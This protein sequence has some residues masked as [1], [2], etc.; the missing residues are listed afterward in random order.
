MSKDNKLAIYLVILLTCC[1]YTTAPKYQRSLYGGWIDADSD[2]QNTRQEVLIEESITPVKLDITGCKVISG[3]WYGLYTGKFYYDP[4]LLDID[5]IVPLKEAHISGAH[6]WKREKKIRYAN[7]LNN[8]NALIAVF[9]GANRQKGAK[10][11]SLWMPSNKQ[12]YCE[13]L[14]HW[15]SIK[16]NWK[17]SIDQREATKITNSKTIY[18][19]QQKH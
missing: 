14:I 10:D 17:L 9:R 7:D 19:L 3:K 1:A 2:C 4:K 6:L 11:P 5:H 15:S 8:K 18:C 13:Y 12:Y 16:Q